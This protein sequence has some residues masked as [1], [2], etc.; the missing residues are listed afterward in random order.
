M[1]YHIMS[2]WLQKIAQEYFHEDSDHDYDV[3]WDYEVNESV[4]E[5]IK[6]AVLKMVAKLNAELLPRL[7]VFKSFRVEFIYLRP[8][9]M[10]TYINGTCSAPV[11]GVD[12][13]ETKAACQKY[14][15]ECLEA[16]EMTILHELGHAIQES[17]GQSL[18]EDEAEIFASSYYYQ[19]EINPP[20]WARNA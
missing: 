17:K 16:V 18:N 14:G 10:G 11:I 5:K 20:E 1:R 13:D 8:G 15:D 2:N 9:E 6:E 7:G 19:K 3:N 4:E 12:V